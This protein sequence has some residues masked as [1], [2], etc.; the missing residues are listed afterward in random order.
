[1]EKPEMEPLLYG[2]LIF[3]KERKNIQWKKD[4][5]FNKWCWGN[6]ASNMQM[7]ES[8]PLS[9]GIYKNKFKMDERP[10]CERGIYLNPGEH[11]QQLL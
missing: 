7:N 11:R 4:Y 5:L 2:Q 10:T 9:Y 6:L 1:M 3:H 8:G